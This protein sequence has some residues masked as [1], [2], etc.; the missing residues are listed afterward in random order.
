[1]ADNKLPDVPVEYVERPKGHLLGKAFNQIRGLRNMEIEKAKRLMFERHKVTY[2][3][4]KYYKIVEDK[5]VTPGGKEFT[6]L[7]LYQLIDG[8]VLTI[9]PE[10][11]A[12]LEGGINHLMEFKDGK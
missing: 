8:A 12:K 5:V 6:E 3:N 10:V 2:R 11:T 7:R 1:M 9:K 4:Q